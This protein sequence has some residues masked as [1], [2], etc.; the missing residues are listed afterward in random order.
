MSP[1][2]VLCFWEL[3]L[4]SLLPV[5]PQP[6]TG[7]HRGSPS[8]ECHAP[9]QGVPQGAGVSL[10]LVR[11]RPPFESHCSRGGG[12]PYRSR[13]SGIPPVDLCPLPVEARRLPYLIPHWCYLGCVCWLE[14]VVSWF[15]GL[16]AVSVTSKLQQDQALKSSLRKQT[17]RL[18]ARAEN[19]GD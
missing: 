18:A 2:L 15:W 4:S 6:C 16:R 19:S 8:L 3:V 10:V 17:E 13:L 7:V 11:L 1:A 9:A 14:Q 12:S 5:L